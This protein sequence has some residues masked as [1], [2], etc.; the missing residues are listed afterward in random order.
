MIIVVYFLGKNVP[1]LMKRIWKKEGALNPFKF[2]KRVIRTVIEILRH[3]WIYYYILYGCFAILGM[4][5]QF[6]FSVHL[7]DIVV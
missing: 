3:F 7:L 6:F 2:I 4:Y 1:I 5:H